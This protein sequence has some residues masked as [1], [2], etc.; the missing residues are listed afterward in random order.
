MRQRLGSDD[1]LM[2]AAA[3]GDPAAFS[4]IV[5]RHQ[6]WVRSLMIAF[7]HNAEQAD[8]L[9]QDAFCRAFQHLDG[10]FF[11]AFYLATK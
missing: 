9:T 1:D 8:D 10:D 5:N 2:R 4:E 11:H 6:A 3:G 7:V